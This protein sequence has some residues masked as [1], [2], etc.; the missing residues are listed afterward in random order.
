MKFLDPLVSYIKICSSEMSDLNQQQTKIFES[1]NRQLEILDNSF[2]EVMN[3]L[4]GL[5]DTFNLMEKFIG[6]NDASYAR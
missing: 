3:D 6:A 1:V 4:N 2:V 5:R